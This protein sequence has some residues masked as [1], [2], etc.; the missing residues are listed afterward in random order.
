VSG[1]GAG[2][3]LGCCG[4]TLCTPDGALSPSFLTTLSAAQ[5]KGIML[6]HDINNEVQHIVF[7][8]DFNSYPA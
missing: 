6:H 5:P 3:D 4:A 2:V 8:Y 7:K 1:G